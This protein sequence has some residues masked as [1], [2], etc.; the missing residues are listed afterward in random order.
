MFHGKNRLAALAALTALVAYGNANAHH[1]FAMFDRKV[2]AEVSGAVKDVQWTNPHVYVDVVAKDDAG[3]TATWTF[4]AGAPLQLEASGL[5][6]DTL[7]PGDQVTIHMHPLKS[8]AS[9]GELTAVI[10]ADGKKFKLDG[11]PPADKKT[12]SP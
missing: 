6:R 2:L 4:E 1:S 11:A 7:K 3:T 5:K 8:G 12:V 10:T 9:G